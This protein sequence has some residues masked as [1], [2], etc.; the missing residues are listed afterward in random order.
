MDHEFVQ[1]WAQTTGSQEDDALGAPAANEAFGLTGSLLDMILDEA[2]ALN[3]STNKPWT[4]T[5]SKAFHREVERLVLW[6][7]RFSQ[8]S[9]IID[10]ILSQSSEIQQT[11]LL[12]L[13]R[14]GSVFERAHQHSVKS[15]GKLLEQVAFVLDLTPRLE[16]DDDDSEYDPDEGDI[17]DRDSE[18]SEDSPDVLLEDMICYIDCLYDMAPVLENPVCDLETTEPHEQETL[19]K[20]DVSSDEALRFCMRIRDRFKK[21][22]KRLVERLGEANAV[23]AARLKAVVEQPVPEVTIANEVVRIE[24]SKPIPGPE[25]VD[26]QTLAPSETLLSSIDH[27]ATNTTLSSFQPESLF[28]TGNPSQPTNLLENEEPTGE[29]HDDFDDNASFAT[30]ASAST[31]FSNTGQGR[32][33]VP[34]LPTEAYE[35]GPFPCIVCKRIL[36]GLWTRTRWK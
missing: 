30:F 24:A 17:S 14:L 35:G 36:T 1:V 16:N 19:E 15:L 31:S 2:V 11:V 13:Y 21:L 12:S 8:S 28:D 23:R 7:G 20:F 4:K 9:K 3:R 32:P 34:A 33:R 27:R 18:A 5:Q 26:N 22:E 29:D 6:K 10:E 25:T